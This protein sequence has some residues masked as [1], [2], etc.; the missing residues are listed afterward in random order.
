MNRLIKNRRILAILIAVLMV[1]NL[2]FGSAFAFGGD[3][4]SDAPV[5]TENG[6]VEAATIT[7][8]TEDETSVEGN[9]SVEEASTEETASEDETALTDE[10]V[11]VKKA[12]PA[13]K[14][15]PA[16]TP[17]ADEEPAEEEP[18]EVDQ[19][20]AAEAGDEE[21]DDI[22]EEVAETEIT[23]VWDYTEATT[24]GKKYFSDVDTSN[25]ATIE[26][27]DYVNPKLVTVNTS[28]A[29]PVGTNKSFKVIVGEGLEW[30]D[31]GADDPNLS[32][33]LTG[34][35]D[36]AGSTSI[37]SKTFKDGYRVYSL[38]DT[39]TSAGVSFKVKL[40]TYMDYKQISDAIRIEATYL[41]EGAEDIAENYKT[42]QISLA[43]LECTYPTSQY[44]LNSINKNTTKVTS[45]KP[46]VTLYGM[47]TYSMSVYNYIANVTT[48]R[49]FTEYEIVVEADSRLTYEGSVSTGTSVTYSN[50]ISN[51]QPASTEYTSDGK[52]IYT[53]KGTNRVTTGMGFEG[54][55][56]IPADAVAG[57]TFEVVCKSI[58]Y[59]I[60]GNDT[61]YVVDDGTNKLTITALGNEVVDDNISLGVTDGIFY[62][63]KNV[64][65][66]QQLCSYSVNN[67]GN[68]A[69]LP[70]VLEMT[71]PADKVDVVSVPFF[72]PNVKGKNFA[73]GAITYKVLG[74]DTWRVYN[75][76][77][78]SGKDGNG[79][80]LTK[81]ELGLSDGEYLEGIKVV[82][83]FDYNGEHV[84]INPI[85]TNTTWHGRIYA[86]VIDKNNIASDEKL[87]TKISLVN[88]DG[89][90]F[91]VGHVPSEK[92]EKSL[93]TTFRT[94]SYT[95]AYPACTAKVL[96]VSG[97]TLNL[98]ASIN[99]YNSDKRQTTLYPVIYI[100]DETGIG[101]SNVVLS[102]GS[103]DIIAKHG[104]EVKH[105]S[106]E[107]DGTLVYKID[108]SPLANKSVEEGRYDAI[109]GH[110][111]LGQR[112]DSAKSL[113]LSYS[114]EV[115]GD[116]NDG[117]KV[118]YMKDAIYIGSDFDETLS[119]NTTVV[120]NSD[121]HG[122]DGTVGNGPK[123][124]LGGNAI[125]GTYT[126]KGRSDVTV[127]FA[128]KKSDAENYEAYN[129]ESPIQVEAGADYNV[130]VTVKNNSD[131]STGDSDTYVYIPIP[132]AGDSWGAGNRGIDSNESALDNFAYSMVITGFSTI[133]STA[134]DEA[135]S[136]DFGTV[137]A[138]YASNAN[139]L[140]I[141]GNLRSLPDSA[142]SDAPSETT[143]C[144]RI[145][146]RNL[147]AQTGYDFIL[148]ISVADDAVNQQF[149][150][151][152]AIYYQDF[153]AHDIQ[154]IGDF[155][156]DK[157]GF[158][159]VWGSVDGRVYYDKDRNGSYSAGDEVLPDVTVSFDGTKD[160]NDIVPDDVSGKYSVKEMNP[161]TYSI[162]VDNI[163]TGYI[164]PEIV[165]GEITIPTVIDDRLQYELTQDIP[166]WKDYTEP[167]E[168]IDYDVT[169]SADQYYEDED[170]VVTAIGCYPE[171][172]MKGDVMLL[173]NDWHHD[174]PRGDWEV[175][176]SSPVK[177][178]TATFNQPVGK[179][180]IH[181]NFKK[182]VYDGNDWVEDGILEI[183]R[184]YSVIKR[185][186]M[187]FGGSVNTN[188]QPENNTKKNETNTSTSQNTTNSV[189]GVGISTGSENNAQVDTE[190]S[191]QTNAEAGVTETK[192]DDTNKNVKND[193]KKESAN[194]NKTVQESTSKEATVTTPTKSDVSTDNKVTKTAGPATG[195]NTHMMLFIWMA[196]IS[197]F[198]CVSIVIIKK[199]NKNE[200]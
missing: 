51:L 107:E 172:P 183:T 8:S 6:G 130:K 111:A 72:F 133:A 176:A 144:V 69:S 161:D 64:G 41:P 16:A 131:Q 91:N 150:E 33:Y 136:V 12:L 106:T 109:V 165:P 154:Y 52:A 36:L 54:K 44:P 192:A 27:T 167:I 2:N 20:E 95:Y 24:G 84:G 141:G 7:D 28:V 168:G 117:G 126:I 140:T 86:K 189:V 119:Y 182:F 18:A 35:T 193:E 30:V 163:P 29:Y 125:S 101:I 77:L 177:E 160:Y 118:H 17:Q 102:N 146:A 195:D 62:T 23:A 81:S 57:D 122:I 73:E 186:V 142:W 63:G 88:V 120:N 80:Y 105:I 78:S 123:T 113:K 178:R 90:E 4:T 132:K 115:P 184:D 164:I 199:K 61:P 103:E 97:E 19:D 197:F 56:K 99:Y 191:V 162:S 22:P 152:S 181:V 32:N 158:K 87:T 67:T 134:D 11:P 138:A 190:T 40:N 170:I 169:L 98:S 10:T 42:T 34:V 121:P 93:S 53:F 128:A 74:E 149:N 50:C 145:T 112:N 83:D 185:T 153:I 143:N 76:T 38:K 21:E 47:N 137:N 187:Q 48:D 85:A 31:S 116:Y 60:K 66:V 129:S 45:G 55:W 157:V 26:W 147:K 5:V 49:W 46:G 82:Y 1:L 127:S 124:I 43:S 173:A 68:E 70:K 79:S 188:T 92:V 179:Y 180:T 3:D 100:R 96:A 196:I 104:L 14:A 148:N 198:I 71:F 89:T 58:S 139:A 37:G 114:I 194:T 174:D 200:N 159:V 166:I 75:G 15:A 135:F 65:D 13:M 156:S 59:K 110:S 151:Y 9:T 175:D 171:S 108:T 39:T 155:T 25:P 94:G